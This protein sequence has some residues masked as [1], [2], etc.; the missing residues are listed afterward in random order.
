MNFSK[1]YKAFLESHSILLKSVI[2]GCEIFDYQPI[3]PP[4][5]SQIRSFETKKLGYLAEDFFEK[6]LA[7]SSRYAPIR[8]NIQII[9]QGI[10][11]GE[12]DF[13]IEDLPSG[14]LIH[15]ELAFKFYLWN[16]QLGTE[17]CAWIGPNNKDRLDLKLEHFKTR[18]IPLGHKQYPEL[19]SQF[20][21]LGQLYLPWKTDFPF[22]KTL[23][24]SS[25]SGF[26]IKEKDLS[27]LAAYKFY[28]VDKLDWF[29]KPEINVNWKS[30]EQ[31]TALVNEKMNNNKST[32]FWI[33]SPEGNLNKLFVVWW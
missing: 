26:W 7:D 18:Q 17:F 20:L 31:I 23:N 9:E 8:R 16:P 21:I 30:Y 29:L 11:L 28:Y 15:L 6:Y 2:P 14:N 19:I 13:I 1:H 4:K 32:L 10:T 33:K 3:A 22:S 12:L 27:T 25:L 24:P 5:A